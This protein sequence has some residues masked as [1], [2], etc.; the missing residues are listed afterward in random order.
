V[1]SFR[2]PST[3]QDS[4]AVDKDEARDNAGD[5]EKADQRHEQESQRDR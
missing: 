4:V 5:A 1:I 3:D 2:L